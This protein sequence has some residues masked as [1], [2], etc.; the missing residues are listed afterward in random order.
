MLRIRI[1]LFHAK[2]PQ[3]IDGSNYLGV[4]LWSKEAEVEWQGPEDIDKIKNKITEMVN[5]FK[6]LIGSILRGCKN[7]L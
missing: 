4:L 6:N 1:Q 5:E 3:K 7:P 2:K